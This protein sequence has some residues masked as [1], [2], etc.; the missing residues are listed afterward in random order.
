MFTRKHP[1]RLEFNNQSTIHD[2]IGKVISD[3][4]TV[5]VMD[6]QIL[7]R[8]NIVSCFF[9]PMLQAVL[10]NFFQIA[11]GKIHMNTIRNLPHL[12]H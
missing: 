1:N 8:F 5:L 4:K 9:K 11:I 7:L 3:F 10:I 12:I 2:E 6:F